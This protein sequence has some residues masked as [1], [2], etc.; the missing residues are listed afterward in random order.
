MVKTARSSVG[1]PPAVREN[2]PIPFVSKVKKLD[3]ADGGE[4]EKTELIKL[5]FLMDPANPASK[6]SR[7]FVIFKDGCPEEWI[8]WLM[9]F[10][11]MEN[12]MPLKEPADK[13]KMFRTLLKGQALSYFEHHL[14]KRLD[15]E[16][17]NIPDN[18]LLELVIRDIGL[19]YIPKRAIRVQKYYMRRGLYMGSNTSVQ[20]FVERLND[21][22]RYLLFFPEESPKQLDQDEIIEI[23]D[24]A[25][26]PEWHEAMVAANIDIFEMSY[27]ESVA[28]FK[29]L[30][31]LEKIKK[32]NGMAPYQ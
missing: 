19:E 30:E 23:L 18:D 11:E 26:A 10:R 9:A 1:L 3:K 28:Y 24:Q 27:E 22:N 6:Y 12:L 2:P 21:L 29:R 7:Q 25:K 4:V 32:T 17:S 31:N 20:Q 14:R 8:K 16:D 15:A 13:T 5:E